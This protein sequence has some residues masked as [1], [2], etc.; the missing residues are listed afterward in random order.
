MLY[1]SINELNHNGKLLV[2]YEN[3]TAANEHITDV[4]VFQKLRYF[5]VSSTEGMV[6]VFKY[7]PTGKTE[8]NNHKLIHTFKGHT[9]QVTSIC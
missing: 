3:L 7:I 1:L 9:K 5:L 2:Q 6:H 8:I 4:L